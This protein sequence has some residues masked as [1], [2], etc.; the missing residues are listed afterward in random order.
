MVYSVSHLSQIRIVILDTTTSSS[1]K[2]ALSPAVIVRWYIE[3]I[4]D[5]EESMDWIELIEAFLAAKQRTFAPNTRRA[6]RYVNF[7]IKWADSEEI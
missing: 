6:Y 5:T 2:R 1:R 7:G 4:L 3:I